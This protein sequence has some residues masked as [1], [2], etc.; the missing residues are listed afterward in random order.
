MSECERSR[1][2]EVCRLVKERE[3]RVNEVGHVSLYIIILSLL[4][5]S[6]SPVYVRTRI[7]MPVRVFARDR[8][9]RR[10]K[11]IDALLGKLRLTKTVATPGAVRVYCPTLERRACD[12]PEAPLWVLPAIDRGPRSRATGERDKHNT[13]C[14]K[15]SVIII[16]EEDVMSCSTSDPD[17]SHATEEEAARE[18]GVSVL[19]LRL[20]AAAGCPCGRYLEYGPVV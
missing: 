12:L 11:S 10:K 16:I 1:E 2:N 18:L 5:S 13:T 4:L 9:E 20:M 6:S 19:S 7:C 8:G 3:G 14:E 17:K 15:I